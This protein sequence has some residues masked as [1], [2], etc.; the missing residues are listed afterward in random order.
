MRIQTFGMG[1]NQNPGKP[2]I[3]GPLPAERGPFSTD[4][5]PLSTN[6]PN[7]QPTDHGK[8]AE[9]GKPPK[10]QGFHG[11]ATIT[12]DEAKEL[13][14]LLDTVLAP[15]TPEEAN[16]ELANHVCLRELN[17]SGGFPI[18]QRLRDRLK[19]FIATAAPTATF[20]ISHGELVVTGK[21][22]ECAQALG[23]VKTIK[24]VK[25]VATVGGVAAGGAGLLWLL[26]LL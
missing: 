4:H 7:G 25:T 26:G 13:S 8:P 10:E 6:N 20:E 24:T 5:G 1:Q 22:V 16:T 18:V 15:V 9:P 2:P 11:K 21:A 3:L 17:D 12:L 14:G 19:S 23:R